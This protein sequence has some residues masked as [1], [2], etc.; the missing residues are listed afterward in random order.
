MFDIYLPTL[1][2]L[3][4]VSGS[5]ILQIILAAILTIGVYIRSARNY[6]SVFIKKILR[7]K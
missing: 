6:F 4:P 2:Y 3:D 5:Y 7:K 1:N